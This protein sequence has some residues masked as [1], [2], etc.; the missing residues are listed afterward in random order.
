MGA[1]RGW[2][3]GMCLLRKI[4]GNQNW[5]WRS[6]GSKG[7]AIWVQLGVG[8]WRETLRG[9]DWAKMVVEQTLTT[10]THSKRVLLVLQK[11]HM[12]SEQSCEIDVKVMKKLL[13]IKSSII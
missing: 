3:Q 5:V 4:L 1:G 13:A 2:I 9:K 10:T 12:Y 11:D 7:G 6:S 8:L